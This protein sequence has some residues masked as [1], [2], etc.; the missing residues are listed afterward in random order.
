MAGF[1]PL[2]PVSLLALLEASAEAWWR[3]S[4]N[5][6]QLTLHLS[7]ENLPAPK[8]IFGILSEL[9]AEAKKIDLPLTRAQLARIV[10]YASE[11]G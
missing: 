9:E 4:G 1:H 2:T 3:L 10:E 8:D 6:S 5:V 11:R 7:N